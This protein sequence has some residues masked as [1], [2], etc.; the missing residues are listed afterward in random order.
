[1]LMIKAPMGLPASVVAGA[2]GAVP[3]GL[4]KPP[5]HPPAEPI[6]IKVPPRPREAPEVDRPDDGEGDDGLRRAPWLPDMPPP[7]PPEERPRQTLGAGPDAWL[8][9]PAN[10]KP[11]SRRQAECRYRHPSGPA[12]PFARH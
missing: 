9:L 5:A 3:G 1:M 4:P 6:I 2:I 11:T 10:V 7:R 8:S 12:L